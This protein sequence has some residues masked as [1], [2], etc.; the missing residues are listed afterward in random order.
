[1]HDYLC[2]SACDMI[3]GHGSVLCL[4]HML[5]A[6][7]FLNSTF[8]IVILSHFPSSGIRAIYHMICMLKILIIASVMIIHV[9]I[10]KCCE[11]GD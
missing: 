6:I 10:Y 5:H 3:F 8:F 4:M 9:D 1:M 2:N 7:K 11:Y